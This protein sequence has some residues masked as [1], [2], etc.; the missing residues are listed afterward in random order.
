MSLVGGPL[1]FRAVATAK[2]FRIAHI[3]DI[4]CGGAHFVPSLMDR[5]IA[6]IN[7]MQPDLVICSGDLT[8]FGFKQEYHEA[9]AYLD[10]IECEAFVVIPGNHDSR[11]VGYVHFEELF[12]E[13]SSVLRVG[14]IT[15]V[16]V[17]STQPDLDEGQIGRGRHG[18]TGGQFPDPAALGIFLM[19]H[20]LL[21]IP[22]TG[23]ERNIVFDAG[24]AIECLQ[25]SGV[26][27]VLSGHK[28]VP[29]AW[30]LEDLFVINAGTVS[31][32]RLRGKTR[33]CYNL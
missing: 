24:D 1:D 27:I 13:R 33:P 9:K 4:H 26:D 19:H 3:S 18:W 32:Q 16:A 8:T 11:N 25:R 12:G 20:H 7:E 6:E 30:R 5:A 22:G 10:K 14:G 21:P 31:S 17:D 2:P 15:V 28:H 23:R 29:Y